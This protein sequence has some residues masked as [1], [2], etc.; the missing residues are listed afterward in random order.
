MEF[1]WLYIQ[2]KDFLMY[3]S[4]SFYN[5]HSDLNKLFKHS[6]KTILH[7]SIFIFLNFSQSSDQWLTKFESSGFVSTADYAETMQ[8]FKNLADNSTTPNFFLSE[9][10][11]REGN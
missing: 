9:F 3:Y 8:Y 11:R 4:K 5:L 7:R 10:H 2:T 1:I 6:M